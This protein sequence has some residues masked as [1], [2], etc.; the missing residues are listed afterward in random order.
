MKKKNMKTNGAHNHLQQMPEV[1][2]G[3]EQI[4]KETTPRVLSKA[5]LEKFSEMIQENVRLKKEEDRL[6][7]ELR[8]QAS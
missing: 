4:D 7:R 8:S 1:F 5:T 2:I 6:L 3:N